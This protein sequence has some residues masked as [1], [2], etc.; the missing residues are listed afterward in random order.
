MSGGDAW[1]SC[2]A[3]LDRMVPLP[4]GEGRGEG[5]RSSQT[6]ESD[7]LIHPPSRDRLSH[8]PTGAGTSCQGVMHGFH[9][10][11]P[12]TAWSLSLRERVGERGPDQAKHPSPIP[13]FTRHRGTGSPISRQEQGGIS[14]MRS[15]MDSLDFG[16]DMWEC[17]CLFA[18]SPRKR[19]SGSTLGF[20]VSGS[21][22]PSS[23][24]R[25]P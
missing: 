2:P 21:R 18:S 6:P 16:K 14:A 19:E 12:S 24:L 3:A 10:L 8:L 1:I 4:P 11:P 13:S 15:F 23:A 9:V 17:S 22:P 20:P 25:D 7:P 5:T